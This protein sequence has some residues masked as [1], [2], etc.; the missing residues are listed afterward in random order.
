[1]IVLG[2]SNLVLELAFQQEEGDDAD[3]IVR[4]AEEKRIALVIPACALFEPY[5]TPVCKRHPSQ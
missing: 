2:E 4:M 5:E 1:M 3:L